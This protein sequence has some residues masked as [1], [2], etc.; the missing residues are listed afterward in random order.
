MGWPA[1]VVAVTCATFL[2]RVIPVG[3]S[4]EFS[5]KRAVLLVVVGAPCGAFGAW[6]IRRSRRHLT[7]VL[8]SIHASVDNERIVLFLRSFADDPEF[9]RQHQAAHTEEEQLAYAVA[10]FGRMVALGRPGDR[11]PQTGAARHYAGDDQWQAQVLAALRRAN[12]I[13]L[14][15]GRGRSLRWEVE[16]VVSDNRPERL[17]LI[18]GSDA[19]K[20]QSFKASVGDL[21]PTT[22]PDYLPRTVP[23]TGINVA[24]TRAVIWFDA[25][26]TPHLRLLGAPANDFMPHDIRAGRLGAAFQ[27]A[28]FPVFARASR[29]DWNAVPRTPPWQLTVAVVETTVGWLS[30]AAWISFPVT[31]NSLSPAGILLSLVPVVMAALMLFEAWLRGGTVLLSPVAQTAIAVIGLLALPSYSPSIRTAVLI[32]AINAFTALALVTRQPARMWLQ[33]PRRVRRPGTSDPFPAGSS[34]GP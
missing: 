25:D 16:Q 29:P 12:L 28:L 24:Y 11:L 10:G 27:S 31:T 18:V 15:C 7:P 3:S 26:W 20:Y 30:L 22:L 34:P 21:F 19:A 13:L 5:L 14:A 32:F 6:A 2:E 17:V 33:V 23:G 8:P 4:I 9:A 1:V